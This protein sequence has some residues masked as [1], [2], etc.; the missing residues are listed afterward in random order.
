MYLNIRV[1][2]RRVSP[3]NYQVSVSLL[4]TNWS[5]QC[6]FH[7]TCYSGS[8]SRTV[9]FLQK[10]EDFKPIAVVPRVCKVYYLFSV[11]LSPDICYISTKCDIDGV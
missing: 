11:F 4:H 3:R 2:H 10:Q 9:N 1:V 6:D 8:E 7:P 5:K